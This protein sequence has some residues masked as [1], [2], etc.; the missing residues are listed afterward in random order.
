MDAEIMA[1]RGKCEECQQSINQSSVIIV[2]DV[3]E[4][5]CT[6]RVTK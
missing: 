2:V 1:A 5:T 4:I 3:P 6:T